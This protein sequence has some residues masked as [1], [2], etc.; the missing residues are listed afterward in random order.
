MK[1]CKIVYISW[2]NI[3]RLLFRKL[4]EELAKRLTCLGQAQV[5]NLFSVRLTCRDHVVSRACSITEIR[6][7]NHGNKDVQSRK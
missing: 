7:F 2:C 4:G 1:Y 5:K 3:H 6:M